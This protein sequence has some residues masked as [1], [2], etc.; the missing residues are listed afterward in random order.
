MHKYSHAY[1]GIQRHAL[2]NQMSGC[3]SARTK[4]TCSELNIQY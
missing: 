4:L 3:G 1:A 2:T